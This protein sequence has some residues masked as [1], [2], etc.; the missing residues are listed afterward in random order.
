MKVRRIVFTVLAI[1][2]MAVIFTFSSADGEES[3]SL[4]SEVGEIFCKIFVPGFDELDAAGQQELIEK[5]DYP[6]R[7]A[8]HFTEYMILG[9]LLSGA[10]VRKLAEI[11]GKRLL[12]VFV[13]GTLY[14]VSDESH[15]LF[16]ADRSGKWLDVVIDSSGV[17][18]SV[19][20][21]ALVQKLFF[22]RQRKKQDGMAE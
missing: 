9:I 12:A 17:L 1:A 3:G 20:L 4:S 22:K 14:A 6:I 13:I 15:Q 19:F 18:F 8:A 2:W 16:V 11:E 21:F 7:K 10:A 5:V